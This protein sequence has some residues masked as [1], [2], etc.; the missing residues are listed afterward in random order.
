MKSRARLRV[1]TTPLQ[2]RVLDR[3]SSRPTL[4]EVRVLPTC[5]KTVG[6][7]GKALVAKNGLF[8]K[9]IHVCAVTPVGLTNRKSQDAP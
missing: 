8:G 6:T 5:E 4:Q 2:G 3:S 1:R 9:S 7:D